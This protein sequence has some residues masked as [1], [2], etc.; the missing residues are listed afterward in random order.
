MKTLSLMMSV[1]VF[2]ASGYFFVTDLRQTTELNYLIYMSLL[3]I[4]MLICIVGVMINLPMIL[5]QRRKVR[6]LIYNSYSSKRIPNKEF[7]KQLSI[8]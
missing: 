4:L 5:R 2:V 1:V 3:V 8:H 7:D 6:T